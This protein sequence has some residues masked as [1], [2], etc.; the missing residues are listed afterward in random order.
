ML[1]IFLTIVA[2]LFSINLFREG[3]LIGSSATNIISVT[4]KGEMDVKP[5]TSSIT[6][7]IRESGKDAK[8][9][10]GKITAKSTKFLASIKSLIEEKDIKTE[11]YNSYPRYAYPANQIAKIDGYEMSQVITLKVRDLK[12]VGKVLELIS[13]AGIN[14]VAGPN[15]EIGDIEK[16]KTD[17]RALAIKDAKVKAEVLAK[18]LG[19]DLVRIVN[20]SEGGDYVQPIYMRGD[21][22]MKTMSAEVAQVP[23]LPAGENKVSS[24]V[25]ITFEIK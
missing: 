24:N 18:Q 13:A 4:G 1:A 8:E 12:N 5:D 19:V 21:A 14:E 3:R 11:S 20:F 17:T 22:M 16:Y 10:E 25:T 7:T 23:V 15:Y 9:G 2:I 6:L